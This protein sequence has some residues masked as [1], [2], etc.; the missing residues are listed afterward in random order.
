MK[1]NILIIGFGN[2]GFRHF[3]SLYQSDRNLKITIIEKRITKSKKILKKFYN[4]KKNIKIVIHNSLNKVKEK[5]FFLSII[6]TSSKPRYLIFKNVLSKFKIKHIILEKVIFSNNYQFNTSLELSKKYL[7]KIWVNLPRR[8]H[9]VTSYIKNKLNRKKKIFIEYCASNWGMASNLIHFMDF[10]NWVSK[11][12]KIK[13][14][15]NKISKK[16]YKS[17]RKGFH[18]IRGE[19]V[20]KDEKENILKVSDKKN[21]KKKFLIKNLNNLYKI[22]DNILHI[23]KKIH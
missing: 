22:S 8:E 15:Q 14:Y 16:L 10:L 5:F 21:N 20:F 18:E 19:I 11:S 3:Q 7:T 9:Q 23:K 17:K 1:N 12:K 4:K 2:I 6:A 13:V